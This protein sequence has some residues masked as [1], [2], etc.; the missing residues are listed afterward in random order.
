PILVLVLVTSLVLLNAK[1]ALRFNSILVI[2][3]FSALAL[4]V[5][6]GIWNIKFDNWSNFAPYGFGQIYGASTGIMAGAS[7][8][9]FGFLG[10][11]SISMAVD[12]VKTPQ[13]NIPRGI[14]LSLSIVT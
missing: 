2:L 3:K 1:A 7:L 12:E 5:L 4:F 13:K 8:M 11:E 9:F 6:V 14:V 10:F